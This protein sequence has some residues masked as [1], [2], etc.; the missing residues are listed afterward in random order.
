MRRLEMYSK[1]K[2]EEGKGFQ[3][4]ALKKAVVA[5]KLAD[6]GEG[7][8]EC[9]MVQWF[10]K[11]GD[12]VSQF[13]KI[14]EVQS[15]KA[16]VEITSR[17]DG[18]IRKL[19]YNVGD[20]ALVGQPLVDIDTPDETTAVPLPSLP[21]ASIVNSHPQ[22]PPLVQA[23]NPPKLKTESDW[24]Y[25]VPAVRRV[26]R[27]FNV[28]IK[29]VKG[30]GKGGRILKEDI[31]AFVNDPEPSQVVT[32]N[33]EQLKPLN[34]VQRA[35]FKAMTQSLTIPH[36]GYSDE[37][38][39]SGAQRLR[40]EINLWLAHTTNP[41][42]KKISYM[43]IFIKALS[44][45]L[46]E[47]PLLNAQVIEGDVP[48]L[49]YRPQHNISVAIDTPLG[50]MVP[51]VKDVQ[52]LTLIDVGVE[53]NRFQ[54]SGGKL[55]SEEL[56][57]GTITLSNI[58]TIGG[59]YLSPVLVKSQV[60]IGGLGRI[61]TLPRYVNDELVPKPILPVSWSADHRVVDGATM[62]RFSRCWRS[63]VE[64]PLTLFAHLK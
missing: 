38:D 15:D 29:Q 42:V 41:R 62:A 21:K 19:H 63:Y 35:M 64:N 52:N 24:T 18:T 54:V 31:L 17:F 46:E 4:S 8:T 20:M 55:S 37:V 14:C 40:A 50:L 3:T 23:R 26:A 11:T 53:L 44:V 56:S 27:E 60:C 34:G 39:L 7:I 30:T 49:L 10:V 2:F 33:G 1:G 57:G 32:N 36:F 58:G 13:D 25:A 48:A 16:S 51:S 45:A 28:D 12:K 22:V 6:I 9:E 43:P 61:Q 59:T 47:F 5:F